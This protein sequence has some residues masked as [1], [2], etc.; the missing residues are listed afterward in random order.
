[1][2]LDKL[3]KKYIIVR[4]AEKEY[5][6]PGPGQYNIYMGF[7]KISK[8]KAIAK[9]QIPHKQENLIPEEVLKN[10]V[11]NKNNN[12][13]DIT[14]FYEGN[15]N[16]KKDKYG[17]NNSKSCGNIFYGGENRKDIRIFK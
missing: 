3:L 13:S 5:E 1:M 7:D 14:F 9:L 8:D 4:N 2:K 11:R 10:Y 16:Y 6:V 15:D 12:N 17:F